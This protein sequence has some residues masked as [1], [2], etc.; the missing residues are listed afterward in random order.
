[1]IVVSGKQLKIQMK[2]ESSEFNALRRAVARTIDPEV[3]EHYCSMNNIFGSIEDLDA[4]DDKTKA[5]AKSRKDYTDVIDFLYM[6]DAEGEIGYKTC[7]KIL[8]LLK[9]RYSEEEIPNL[10]IFKEILTECS[11]RRHRMFWLER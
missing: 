5:L 8:D 6:Y 9:G 1:M 10:K 7:A 3:Y 4:Y 2:L 11:E